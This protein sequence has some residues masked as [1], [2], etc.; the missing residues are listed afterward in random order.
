MSLFARFPA[1]KTR[2]DIQCNEDVTD[3]KT[4]LKVTTSSI[5]VNKDF[6][7]QSKFML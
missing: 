4:N 1:L 2:A 7:S 3:T 6:V 5:S